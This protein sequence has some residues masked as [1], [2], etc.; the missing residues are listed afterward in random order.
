MKVRKPINSNKVYSKILISLGEKKDYVTNFLKEF[1][2]ESRK[3]QP[4]LRKQL[5]VLKD[6]GYVI[7]EDMKDGKHFEAN[8][9]LFCINW[10]KI[11][12]EFLEYA[13]KQLPSNSHSENISGF[14]KMIASMNFKESEKKKLSKNYWLQK[15][16]SLWFKELKNSGKFI[17]LEE[18]FEQV[19]RNNLLIEYP[20]KIK[21][22]QLAKDKLGFYKMF[23]E[24][25]VNDRHHD[26]KELQRFS[27]SI[28]T[29]I[30]S[31]NFF[32]KK[33]F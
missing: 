20:K 22:I 16:F 29:S 12:L 24:L 8:K 17:T 1:S 10:E 23:P 9:K 31:G 19:I 13:Q 3:S 27:K 21:E 7:E 6:N 26:F 33:F 30:N 25:M 11:V 28:E 4:V 18:F 2:K 32:K 14:K 15:F 5:L